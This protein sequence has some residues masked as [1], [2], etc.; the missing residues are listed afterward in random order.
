MAP[1]ASK[2]TLFIHTK[3]VQKLLH[4][5]KWEAFNEDISILPKISTD[6]YIECIGGRFG[7][8]RAHT[9]L[10]VPLWAALRMEQQQQCSIEVPKWL[11]EEEL[12]VMCKEEQAE[13]HKFGKVHRHY[14]EIATALLA[15]PRIFAGSEKSR[16]NIVLQL[17][18]LIELRRNKILDGIKAFDSTPTE[19]NVTGM[20]AA[21]MTCFRTRSLHFLDMLMDLLRN[22]SLE[23]SGGD[24][25]VAA[26][27]T[28]DEDS[29]RPI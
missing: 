1:L 9:P 26:E 4:D 8:L 11:E 13:P 2:S 12:K 28:R 27:D 10:K 6:S 7:P 29:S 15:R 17:N 16:Q 5:D 25:D 20:S 3:D 19:F 18:Q 23:K 14:I 22:R 24:V 21:E